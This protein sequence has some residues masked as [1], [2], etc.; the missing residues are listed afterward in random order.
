MALGL[1]HRTAPVELRERLAF[2]EEDLEE[3]L[4][5]L[6]HTKSILECTILSTCNRMPSCHVMRAP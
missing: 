5:R 2:S 3:A 1:N 6:R 4:T